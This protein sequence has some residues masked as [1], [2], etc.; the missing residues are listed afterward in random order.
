MLKFL[1]IY[2]NLNRVRHNIIN[3]F[4]IQL[5]LY[6]TF[7]SF[8][9]LEKNLKFMS[10]NFVSNKVKL[11]LIVQVYIYKV[12]IGKYKLVEKKSWLVVLVESEAKLCLKLKFY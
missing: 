6:A 9:L 8:L 5:T 10:K 1:L 4:N 2:L 11:K 7:Y 3:T 12:A